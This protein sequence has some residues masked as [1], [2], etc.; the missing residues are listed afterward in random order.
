M[1]TLLNIRFLQ[2]K[3]ELKDVGLRSFVILGILFFLV[4]FSYTIFQ[5]TQDALLLISFLFM[6]CLSL[7]SYRKDKSF[8]YNHISNPHFEIFIEYLMLTLPFCLLS[9]FTRNWF[10][11]PIL[12][13]SLYVLPFLKCT[14]KQK[15]YFKNISLIIPAQ[16]FELISGFR[17]SFLF[18]IPL[19]VFAIGSCWF[20]IFPLF[21]L[22]FISISIVSFYGECESL[23]ILKEG[24]FSSKKFLK[25]KF[26]SHSKCILI[27]YAPIVIIHSIFNFDLWLVNLLFIPIQLSLLCFAICLKYS[28]YQPNRNLL[29]SNIVLSLVS[30]ASIFPYFLPIPIIMAFYYYRKAKINLDN[31]LH[32]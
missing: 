26:Y 13:L 20:R 2:I 7:Q 28:S 21:I 4:F 14:L 22:W 6:S 5:K 19:Y 31:F 25:R 30:L 15:T 11:F 32:D 9:L 18:L 16:N 24:N 12:I 1:T 8:V 17:K 10:C 29:A 3:R 23:P 27:L